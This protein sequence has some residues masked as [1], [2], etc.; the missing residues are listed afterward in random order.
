MELTFTSIRD[1]P[2][3]LIASMLK[4]SY[5]DLVD[6][7]QERWG[8]EVSSWEEFDRE[9]FERPH[10]VGACVFLSW[11]DDKLVGFASYDPRQRPDVGIVGHNCVLPEFR[12]NGFGKEQIKEV[13]RRFRTMG[14]SL[15][16]VSTLDTPFFTPARRIYTACGFRETARHPWGVDPLH[17]VIE[18]E[19]RLDEYGLSVRR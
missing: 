15:A 14:I 13:L 3:G 9:V 1:Q 7:D 4:R 6:A 17:Y 8:P 19:V 5:V 10:T 11:W 18:Y 2:S 16:R 12:G